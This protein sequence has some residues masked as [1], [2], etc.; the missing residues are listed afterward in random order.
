MRSCRECA[1]RRNGRFALREILH[2]GLRASHNFEL[3]ASRRA[4]LPASRGI[5]HAGCP[6]DAQRLARLILEGGNPP[7]ELMIVEHEPVTGSYLG[8]GALALYYEGDESVRLK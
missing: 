3:R 4:D 8:P 7:A 5:S 1:S 2:I 6:E